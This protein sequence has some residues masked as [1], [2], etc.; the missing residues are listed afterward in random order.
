MSDVNPLTVIFLGTQGSGKGT[1]LRLVK[2]LLQEKDPARDI[3][4][5]EMG[6]IL[7]DLHEIDNFTGRRIK[8]LLVGGNLIPFAVSAS[9]FTLY[10]VDHIMTGDEHVLID[11]F[12]R[13]PEQVPVLDS[14]IDF[15][16]RA[17]PTVINMQISDEEAI[18]RL[19]P[20]G[21]YDDTAEGIRKR[22]K[23]SEELTMP[24]IKWF[25]ENPKYDVIDVFGER[26]LEEVQHEIRIRLGLV[27]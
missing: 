1:Q 4:H 8:E 20:R 14:A 15:F 13:T 23:W 18:R 6:K 16:K 11:G 7:R 27:A 19:T 21:R 22:M 17:N 2:E 25:K 26:P 24:A 12:P 3:V 9:K 5:V 10:L